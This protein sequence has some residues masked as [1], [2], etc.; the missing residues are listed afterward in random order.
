M[1]EWTA[2][3]GQ[4]TH[5]AP[6]GEV[7]RG[8]DGLRRLGAAMTPERQSDR[9]VLERLLALSF[10]ANRMPCMS[11]DPRDRLS[12]LRKRDLSDAVTSILEAGFVRVL[13]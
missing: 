13:P 5:R 6:T 4:V 2:I 11:G 10:S 9:E 7:D 12:P 3:D 8:G 1:A